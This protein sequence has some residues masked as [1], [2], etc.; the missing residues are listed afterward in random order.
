[1]EDYKK[2]KRKL[3]DNFIIETSI[4]EINFDYNSYMNSY[5]YVDN[6]LENINNNRLYKLNLNFDFNNKYDSLIQVGTDMYN[7]PIYYD[8]EQELRGEY[9]KWVIKEI[10]NKLKNRIKTIMRNGR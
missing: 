1:M 9:L 5:N 4:S 6:L 8:K 10:D 3:I 2:K 7:Q